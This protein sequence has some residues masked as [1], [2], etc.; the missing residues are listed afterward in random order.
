MKSTWP[1]I[2][3][4]RTKKDPLKEC[5]NRKTFV[6]RRRVITFINPRACIRTNLCLRP[7][8]TSTSHKVLSG[9]ISNLTEDMVSAT[10][11]DNGNQNP[12]GRSSENRWTSESR[13][14]QL[15]SMSSDERLW[16]RYLTNDSSVTKLTIGEMFWFIIISYWRGPGQSR[17]TYFPPCEV[18]GSLAK[19]GK[20]WYKNHYNALLL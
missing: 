7:D 3:S 12:T 2:H 19:T 16:H 20:L 5:L 11:R 13:D 14:W 4:T 17:K 6:M 15:E 8:S 9:E 10:H 1:C 18:Q